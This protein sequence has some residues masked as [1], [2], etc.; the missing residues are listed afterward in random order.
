MPALL[1]GVV[2]FGSPGFVGAAVPEAEPAD[3]G[4]ARVPGGTT[5]S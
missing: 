3:V 1:T 2:L 4:S 5:E